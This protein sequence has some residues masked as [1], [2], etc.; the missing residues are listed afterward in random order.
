MA[1]KREMGGEGGARME[2]TRSGRKRETTCLVTRL[3]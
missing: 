1:P 3:D 2:K